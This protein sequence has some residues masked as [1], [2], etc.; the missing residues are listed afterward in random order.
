MLQ[1]HP[2]AFLKQYFGYT[3]FK[4]GQDELVKG[5][6]SGRDVLG[7]MPTGAGKSI[8]YQL[9]AAMSDGVSL[10]ISPLISLMKDQV[11]ALNQI[12]I[13]TASI[14]SSLSAAEM[15]QRFRDIAA[16]KYKIVYV[17]PE[18]IDSERFIR[19]LQQIRVPIVAVDEAHCVSQ[20]G[21]DFRPSYL[22]IKQLIDYIEPRPVIAA[23]TATA[24]DQVKTDIMKQLMLE[25]PLRVTT[26]Y[27]R[28]NLTFSV[29]KGV[30]KR[31]FLADYVRSR[32]TDCGVIYAS[33]RKEVEDCHKYLLRLGIPAGR[34][35]AGLSDEER[36]DSQER[37]LYDDIR[38]MVATNA[39]GMGIDK[40][41]VRYVIH[42]NLPKNIESYYQEAGRAGRDGEPGECIVLYAAQDIQMQKFL[43]E[44]SESELER[45]QSE[46]ANLRSMVDYC[47]TTDCLQ[48]HIVRYFGDEDGQACG[49]CANCTDDREVT[50]ITVEA[51]QAFS[52]IVRMKQRFGMTLT[53]KVLRG[54]GDS[55]VKE[56]GFDRLPTYGVMSHFKEKD[57]VNLLNVLAADG[58]LRLSDGK[59][60][61]VSLTPRAK[62]VL[63][64]SERV[65]QRSIG[66]KSAPA[67]TSVSEELFDRLRAL[68]RQFADKERVPPFTIFHDATLREMCVQ[69]P[70][71]GTD[72]LA[73]K[74]VGRAKFDKYG[75]AFLEC[76]RTFEGS[77]V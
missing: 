39:F 55:K 62:A 21:H 31:Q 47:H 50:D 75:D 73:V 45:K 68:R 57:I 49:R 12:G 42:Y 8:C 4:K 34:Y 40:S 61:T 71:T 58:Y 1:Q 51:Q 29:L 38:V 63:E 15:S 64:G 33:T 53:A 37:F 70:R 43:I 67:A 9:P 28:E 77:K 54:A 76:I 44:Q 41:N 59:Y 72:M 60:P 23:F 36:A 20:W 19:L 48:R 16:G 2:E 3:S 56:F 24:T 65:F 26:G 14:N 30:D 32:H 22:Q 10:V 17:A 46:Y 35:H 74:G 13:P 25:N 27:A 52:C 7:V 66:V 5:I 18:R 6:L 69:L 11:D